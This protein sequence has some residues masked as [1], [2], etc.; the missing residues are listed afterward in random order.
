[1]SLLISTELFVAFLNCKYK[2]YLKATA[3]SGT[4]SDYEILE[5]SLD[6]DYR[7]RASRCLLG[8]I[9]SDR[10]VESP[11]SIDRAIQQN[12][13]AITNACVATGD[14]AVRFD[15]LLRSS[16]RPDSQHDYLPVLFAS[17]ERISK[18]HKLLLAFHGIALSQVQSGSPRFGI[19]VH[20][21]AFHELRVRIDTLTSTVEEYLEEIRATSAP[22][23]RLNEH[24]RVCEFNSHCR[25]LAM[26]KD[27]LSLLRGLREKEISKLNNK[28]IFTTTQLSYTFRP[29]RRR[30]TRT[31]SPTRHNPRCKP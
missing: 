31:P 2:A 1:M 9:P 20:G 21:E 7:Q 12:F 17:S 5:M 11:K 6:E 14:F 16:A 26:E 10:V 23:F 30:K 3:A 22:Q 24:C 15:A 13:H 18:H 28:G 8:A 29:R 27:D 4:A 25:Q 19:I